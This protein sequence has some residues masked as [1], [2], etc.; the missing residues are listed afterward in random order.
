MRGE[1]G[2]GEGSP[3]STTITTTSHVPPTNTATTNATRLQPTSSSRDRV[4]TCIARTRG[5]TFAKCVPNM[6]KH[7][8]SQALASERT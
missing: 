8:L 1:G 6:E 4:R 3:V 2:K 5:M 7:A